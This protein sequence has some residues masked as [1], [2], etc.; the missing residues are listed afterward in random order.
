MQTAT[1]SRQQMTNK[2]YKTTLPS[3]NEPEAL[4][5]LLKAAE[6]AIERQN[7]AFDTADEYND[8]FTITI[9]GTQT[10]FYLG[11]PQFDA[12]LAFVDHIA[13]ENLYAVDFNKMTVTG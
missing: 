3:Y 9:N 4:D 12:L 13:A 8:E 1:E 7:D 2:N 11:G 10:A 6:A 5:Q